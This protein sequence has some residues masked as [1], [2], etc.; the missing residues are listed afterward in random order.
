[1]F[2][3]FSFLLSL[4]FWQ[5]NRLDQ[6]TN[7]INCLDKR[8]NSA[9]VSIFT[10][11]NSSNYFADT[12]NWKSVKLVGVWDYKNN[13]IF[14]ESRTLKGQSGVN[15]ITPFFLINNLTI[16]IN[17][18]WFRFKDNYIVNFNL[19]ELPVV[20]TG[21]LRIKEYKSLFSP[22][23]NV[24]KNEWHILNIKQFSKYFGIN[25]CLPFFI[26]SSKKSTNIELVSL[27]PD[28]PNNHFSYAITWFSLSVVVF[29]MY[30][31]YLRQRFS[32]YKV[33]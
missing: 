2:F 33:N 21:V 23:N 10:V 15:I 8:L 16:L 20:L 22:K 14:L 13:N 11:L 12:W 28:L 17:R 25:F 5:L 31:F 6:K 4:G 24:N 32:F 18:G 19:S 9:P 26:V 3:L 27:I 7:L 30:L 29:F 1:M